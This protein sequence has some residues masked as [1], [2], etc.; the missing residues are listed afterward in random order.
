MENT[1]TGEEDRLAERDEGGD[2]AGS[3]EQSLGEDTVAGGKRTKKVSPHLQ[4]HSSRGKSR[5]AQEITLGRA[6]GL[7][8]LTWPRPEQQLCTPRN[9]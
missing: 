5:R 1:I 7:K 8:T 4:L 2:L 3:L 9:R 6:S